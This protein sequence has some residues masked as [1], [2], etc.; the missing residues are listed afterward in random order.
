LRPAVFLLVIY[1]QIKNKVFL[2]ILFSMMFEEI[3]PTQKS[4]FVVKWFYPSFLG[5]AC[6]VNDNL[7]APGKNEQ[8]V[9]LFQYPRELHFI[10]KGGV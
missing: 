7:G 5:L 4:R 6:P 10:D 3:N 1:F 9:D 2:I 8:G